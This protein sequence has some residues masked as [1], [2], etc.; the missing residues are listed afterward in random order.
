MHMISSDCTVDMIYLDFSKVFNYS[1]YT[2]SRTL[3]SLVNL[4]YG[5]SNY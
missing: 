2:S 4:A 1:V 3:V 5:F